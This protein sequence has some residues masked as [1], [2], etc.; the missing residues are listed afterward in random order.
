MDIM[1]KQKCKDVVKKK[2]VET[3]LLTVLLNVG[4]IIYYFS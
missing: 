3:F 2:T 4:D 1:R